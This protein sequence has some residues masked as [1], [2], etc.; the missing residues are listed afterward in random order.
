MI[1][2]SK[3]L[4]LQVTILNSN[5][6]Y[7]GEWFQVFLYNINSFNFIMTIILPNSVFS[8]P[9]RLQSENKK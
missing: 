7:T 3:Q 6:L 9:G 4:Q 2:L 5:Y 1:I 8:C